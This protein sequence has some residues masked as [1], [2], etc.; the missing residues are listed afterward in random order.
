V[1]LGDALRATAGARVPQDNNRP[2]FFLK[3]HGGIDSRAPVSRHP[4]RCRKGALKQK[5]VE[6]CITHAWPVCTFYRRRCLAAILERGVE[7]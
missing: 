2:A 7:A 6:S 5:R 4:V 1:R 3:A